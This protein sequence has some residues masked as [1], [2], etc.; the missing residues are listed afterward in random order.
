MA[1]SVANLA[2]EI[3]DAWQR[4]EPAGPAHEQTLFMN[5]ETFVQEHKKISPVGSC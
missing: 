1:L 2:P 4:M 5:L 3:W